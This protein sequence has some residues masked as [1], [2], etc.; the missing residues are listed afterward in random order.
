MTS[1]G[2]LSLLQVYYT[3]CLL[4]LQ[5]YWDQIRLLVNEYI[6][7]ILW[8]TVPHSEPLLPISTKNIQTFMEKESIKESN[9]QFL[10]K[11]WVTV[12]V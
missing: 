9:C 6:I 11:T 12:S 10:W 5:G 1:L 2:M 4:K 3:L 8:A 7:K